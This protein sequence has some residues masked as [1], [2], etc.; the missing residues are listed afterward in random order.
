MKKI[1]SRKIGQI[2]MEDYGISPNYIDECVKKQASNK[3]K[4]FGDIAIQSHIIDRETILRALCIQ[5]GLK[6]YSSVDVLKKMY[7]N[8]YKEEFI[9]KTLFKKNT[10]EEYLDFCFINK[11]FVI[12]YVENES[13]QLGILKLHEDNMNINYIIQDLNK[14]FKSVEIVAISDYIFNYIRKSYESPRIDEIQE[15][16]KTLK[17]NEDSLNS[18]EQLCL[19]LLVFAVSKNISDI[20]I[21]P[22][23]NNMFRISGRID[24][25][26]ELLFYIPSDLGTKLI[27]VIKLK[28]NMST[29]IIKKPQ[30][31]QLSGKEHLANITLPIVT[32]GEKNSSPIYNFNDVSFRIST[33]PNRPEEN[34]NIDTIISN[35][36]MV[37]RTLNG[38]ESLAILENL[39]LSHQTYGEITFAIKKSTGIIIVSG[40][41]GSGK[42][43]SLHALM[44]KT[45]FLSDKIITYEDPVEMR[46]MY[47][48]QGERNV[49]KENI[50]VNFDFLDAKKSILR[51]DPNIILMGEIRD[52]DTAQ[53]ALEAANTGH[54]VLAT[55]HA[56]SSLLVFDRLLELGVDY[57]KSMN[58]VICSFS[59]RLIKHVCP[60]CRTQKVLTKG[61][62][63]L[64]MLGKLE[65]ETDHLI[66]SVVYEINPTGCVKCDHK[67]FKG[68]VI[69]DETLPITNK[70]KEILGNPNTLTIHKRLELNEIGYKTMLDNAITL[71]KDGIIPF[72]EIFKVI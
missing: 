31:G 41:T 25:A 53:F 35:E 4:L 55:L 43:T 67:G 36:S 1:D 21:E 66:D 34:N 58:S 71:T 10:P 62:N 44:G 69:I 32:R 48:T 16:V 27:N 47:W 64:N 33:Y 26:R 23:Y 20:H 65:Y 17:K 12:D 40:P 7:I 6:Y 14:K 45:D 60:H 11:F 52:N 56:N 29:E 50:N 51:Q 13:I 18:V 63:E 15:L 24:G 22:N 28:S 46:N 2:L 8:N 5:Y 54:L 57:N 72:S 42:S 68:R 3:D 39:N 70:V 61:C 30:D 9:Y 19:M 49:N 37:I 59:Q 38:D